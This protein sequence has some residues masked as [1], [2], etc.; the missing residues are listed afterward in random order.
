MIKKS[1]FGLAKQRLEYEALETVLPEPET[2]SVSKNITLLIRSSDKPNTLQK[3]ILPKKGDKVKTG[4]KI[5]LSEKSN[6]YAISSVTG[7]VSS[8]SPFIGN[9][10]EFFTAITIEI[11]NVEEIDNNFS[12]IS[13][14]PTLDMAKNFLL[15]SPGKPRFD[16]LSNPDTPISKLVVCVMDSDI[17]MTTNQHVLKTNITDIKKGID[18]LKTI[19]KVDD[20]V[21]V[22][23]RHLMHEASVLNATVKVVDLSYPS[24]LPKMIMKNLLNNPVPL[25]KTCEELG[26]CF[27]SAEAVASIGKAFDSGHIPFLK[28]LT[29]VKKDGSK[30]T[31]S[32]RIGTPIK[33]IFNTFN[34]TI[35]KQDRIIFGGPMTGYC[36][37]SEDHPVEP[38]TDAIIVQ[39]GK[40]ISHVSDY[41]CINCG[42]CVRICPSKVPVNMLVRFL[43]AGL[44][45]EAAGSYDLYSCIDCGL[46]SYVCVAQIP[47]FQYIK[48]AKYELDRM[49]SDQENSAEEKNA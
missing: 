29:L 43:E 47:I 22:S 12:N 8:I 16:L 30:T 2:I 13:K 20:I 15:H 10:G 3:D 7:T 40:N 17:L 42:E 46:C 14:P 45:E 33:D 9:F 26:V 44:Y 21:I 27:I 34:I 24:V 49:Q 41:P 36:V 35:N 37:Y 1:F 38:D 39:E 32:A 19:A 6:E 4:Q 11:K 48:L 23:P 31:I 5:L 28:T 25:E 18:I